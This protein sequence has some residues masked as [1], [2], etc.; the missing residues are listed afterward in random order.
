MDLPLKIFP[1][2]FEKQHSNLAHNE[3][4]LFIEFQPF[5]IPWGPDFDEPLVIIT[6]SNARC[7]ML[8]ISDDMY[9]LLKKLQD[10]MQLQ[11]ATK[12]FLGGNIDT[13]Y[14]SE[15]GDAK[16]ALDIDFLYQ[17]LILDSSIKRS[18]FDQFE[19]AFQFR[20]VDGVSRGEKSLSTM[21]LDVKDVENIVYRLFRKLS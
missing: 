4:D 1:M 17:F 9:L 12:P 5:D 2:I 20:D 7:T 18:I 11:P 16:N 6:K 14:E 15:C 8:R 13:R 3:S 19:S 10:V 21:Y